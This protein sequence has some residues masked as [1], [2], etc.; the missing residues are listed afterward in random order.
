M[1]KENPPPAEKIINLWVQPRA[2]RN[3]ILG[4]RDGFLRLR[5]TAAPVDGEANRLCQKI[6][7]ESLGVSAS[8]VEILNGQKSRR[9]RVRIKVNLAQ[10]Q[11][12]EYGREGDR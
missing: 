5:V 6:L 7:A 4:Y 1:K 3:E 12:W 2:S 10:W 8:Q 9:K 11:G